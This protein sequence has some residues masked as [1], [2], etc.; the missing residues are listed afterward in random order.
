[1]I[2]YDLIYLTRQIM[3]SIICTIMSRKKSFSGHDATVCKV[4][5]CKE[6]KLHKWVNLEKTEK[7]ILNLF[8]AICEVL[9]KTKYARFKIRT[10][11][12]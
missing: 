5:S 2:Y 3:T 9:F 8:P 7:V 12:T 11:L 6:V 4:H 1:M 10:L